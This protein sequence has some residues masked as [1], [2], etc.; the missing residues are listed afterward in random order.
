MAVGKVSLLLCDLFTSSFGC[1]GLLPSPSTPPATTCAR[2]LTTSFTFM[3][4]WVPDPVCH[5]T[6]GNWS[7]SLLSVISSHTIPIRSHFSADSTP[8]SRLVS[9]AAFFRMANAL[10]IS[11][12]MCPSPIRKLSFERCV[13]APQYLSAG[14]STGPIVSFSMRYFIGLRGLGD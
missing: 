4:L 9:A 11:S 13:C 10:I 5:T 3:L 14:T 7:S 6:S 1:N 2:L 8:R 12:G